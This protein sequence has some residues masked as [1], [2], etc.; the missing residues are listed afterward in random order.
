MSV[1]R[2]GG[3]VWI[4]GALVSVAEARVPVLDHGLLYGDGI[5]EGMRVYAGRAFRLDRHLARLTASARAL[6]LELPGGV[7]G[8]REIVLAIFRTQSLFEPDRKLAIMPGNTMMLTAKMSGIMP[9]EL[10]FNGM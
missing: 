1:E 4:D 5:F 6:S 2:T 7:A 8:I 9:A 3:V 10:T